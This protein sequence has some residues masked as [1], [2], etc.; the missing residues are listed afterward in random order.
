MRE[1]DR[2]IVEDFHIELVQM[3]ENAGRCLAHLA[4]ARF[5]DGNPSG[6][7]VAVLSGIGGNGGGGLI[8]L[9]QSI[10][11]RQHIAPRTMCLMAQLPMSAI[12][13]QIS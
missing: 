9:R 2:L 6:R 10:W 13:I 12:L 4:R 11:H 3:M 1:V 8:Q 7:R 5:L